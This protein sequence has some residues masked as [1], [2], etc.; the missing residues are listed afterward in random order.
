M[1]T[2]ILLMSVPLIIIFS[3]R[4]S[5]LNRLRLLFLF[6]VGI[7]LVIVSMLR[8]KE[9]YNSWQQKDQT[10]WSSLEVLLSVTVAVTPTVY[11]LVRNGGGD[12]TWTWSASEGFQDSR[13]TGLGVVQEVK[14]DYDAWN[15]KGWKDLSRMASVVIRKTSYSTEKVREAEALEA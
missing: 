12:V 2:D 1:L 8:I 14:F 11:G 4:V 3:V 15:P 7:F 9:G 6:S 5:V 13:S 10:L